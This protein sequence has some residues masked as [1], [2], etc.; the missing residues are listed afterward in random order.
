MPCALVNH[1]AQTLN[2]PQTRHGNMFPELQHP[3]GGTARVPGNPVNLSIDDDSLTAPPLLG[4][5]AVAVLTEWVNIA[6]GLAAGVLQRHSEAGWNGKWLPTP[7]SQVFAALAFTFKVIQLIDSTD[8]CARVHSN[9]SNCW[10][11]TAPCR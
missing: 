9:D 5:H 6:D 3:S 7:H 4:A 10:T 8:F 1:V 2:N 11:R